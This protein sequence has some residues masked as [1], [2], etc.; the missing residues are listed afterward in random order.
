MGNR[1]KRVDAYIS[2]SA[3]FAKPILSHLRKLVHDACPQAEETVKWGMPYFDYKGV[4]CHMASFKSHCAFGFWKAALMKDFSEMKD[5]NE[6][7]MGHLGKITSIKEL[8]P[9][10]KITAWIKEAAKL[11]DDSIKLPEKK[12]TAS[13]KEIEMPD[14]LQKAL[15]K[16]KAAAA[17]FSNFSPSHK[18]EYLEWI[19]EAKT[20]ETRHKRIATT[21]D[22]LTE[23]KPR[24]WKYMKK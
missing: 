17:T 12:T 11:N 13:K 8:P 1:D 20:E 23:G 21:I 24:H 14:A 16:N 9:D 19:T 22:W 5:N 10:K 18:Y 2:K 4:M 15:T 6:S 3:D 7:A